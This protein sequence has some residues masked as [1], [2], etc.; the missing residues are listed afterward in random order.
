[1]SRYFVHLPP[2]GTPAIYWRALSGFA[3]ELIQI[4][5]NLLAHTM[6]DDP[7]M[8]LPTNAILV[9]P[10]NYRFG[11]RPEDN[12]DLQPFAFSRPGDDP[13]RPEALPI[14]PNL[15]R[16]LD[17][18]LGGERMNLSLPFYDESIKLGQSGGGWFRNRNAD[19]AYHA[20]TDFNTPD[21]S[22]FD[23]CAAA[24]GRLLA[25]AS[26]RVVLSHHTPGGREFRTVYVHIDPTAVSHAV[27]DTIRRGELLGRT[28]PTTNPVHLH[29]GV[30]VTA[31]AV[32]LGGVAVPALWYFID[33]W[34]VYDLR[35]G[36]YLP[37]DGPIFEADITG[38][39]HTVQWQAQPVFKAIPIA[40]RTDDYREVMRVQVRTRRATNLG[41]SL[42]EEQDQF[43]VW[44]S[45]DPEFFLAPLANATNRTTELEMVALLR[46]AFLHAK[47][48]RLEYRYIGDLRYIMA[49]WVNR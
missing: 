8:S 36:N 1:M 47:P 25:K 18:P 41:G 34:G 21:G 33:P 3:G 19:N 5:L 14:G 46:E 37:A 10:E 35:D 32:T 11:N 43:L 24:D 22:V 27:G 28:D 29:F 31:P 49:A 4:N 48:V 2:D 7:A 38:A 20:A 45:G 13:A 15:K 9:K 42:P 17:D 39:T 6:G 40:R 44:L 23:V 16:F 30:A 26:H 12:V